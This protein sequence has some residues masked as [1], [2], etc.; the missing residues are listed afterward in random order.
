MSIFEIIYLV[1]LAICLLCFLI[2]YI[3]KMPL[4]AF[5]CIFPIVP[6]INTICAIWYIIILVTLVFEHYIILYKKIYYKL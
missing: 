5:D 2:S 1:S 3:G 4:Y 6:V